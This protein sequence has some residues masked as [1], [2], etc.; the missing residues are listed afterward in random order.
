MAEESVIWDF[1]KSK[2]EA[3]EAAGPATTPEAFQKVIEERRRMEE[4]V[5]SLAPK[6]QS[7]LSIALQ[8]ATPLL[9]GILAGRADVGAKVAGEG[10][11]NLQG[12][13]AADQ[14]NYRKS[15]I[16]YLKATTPKI[17]I[18]KGDIDKANYTMIG[19]QNGH[20]VLQNK[21]DKNDTKVDESVVLDKKQASA[22]PQFDWAY[23]MELKR[24]QMKTKEEIAA[25]PNLYTRSFAPAVVI[26]PNTG[27]QGIIN[28]ATSEV[29]SV[30]EYAGSV[31]E[32][33]QKAG[34]IGKGEQVTPFQEKALA[35][36]TERG[37]KDTVINSSLQQIYATNNILAE[38]NS[39]K[40]VTEA[41]V[42]GQLAK[43]ME[44][45][46]VSDA[47]VMRY[48]TGTPSIKNKMKTL[49]NRMIQGKS[50]SDTDK[51]AI[52]EYMKSFQKVLN[53]RVK[54]RFTALVPDTSGRV[55]TP[56]VMK[57]GLENLYKF[58]PQ[59]ET[60]QKA[61]V[62]PSGDTNKFLKDFIEKS[63]NSTNPEILKRVKIAKEKLGVK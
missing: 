18:V 30:G 39:G 16:D 55:W 54:S 13:Q 36:L 37:A 61:A 29:K 9:L 52:V 38:L 59:Q 60:T 21:M 50:F 51:E 17:P 10:I 53:D 24:N 28:R 63:K 32:A 23:N 12:Q 19:T 27:E 58:V 7:D 22:Y 45:A 25:N 47:D 31:G 4:E 6:P 5:K 8:G 41:W 15:L 20:P 49:Y 43:A 35:E 40:T 1:I 62:K 44:D 34:M 33:Q 14:G 2:A 42:P 46:R 26:N 3:D 11:R 56:N 48:S 57:K